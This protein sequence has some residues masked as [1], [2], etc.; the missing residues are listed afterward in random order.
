MTGAPH[1]VRRSVGR[2]F[3]ILFEANVTG[4]SSML[5]YAMLLT[6][7]PVALLGLFVAGQV[8]KSGSVEHSVLRDLSEI[9]PGATKSTLTTL[10]RQIRVSTTKTGVLALVASVW[11]GAS[12]WG[13][14][15]TAFARIYHVPARN[16]WAQKRF[17]LAMLLV[18]LVFMLSMVA[19]PTV[20][21][22]LQAGARSLPFDLAR[23]GGLVYRLSLGFAL[24]LLFASL[25]VIYRAVPNRQVPW[26]AVWPGAAAA[27]LLIA[28]LA[29][30]FPL[31]LTQIS[32]IAQFGTTIVF[33]LIVLAWFYVLAIIILAGGVVNSM[34]LS[35]LALPDASVAADCQPDELD[36]STT[37]KT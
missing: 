22:L 37:V 33:V 4:L 8:L 10:L 28:V 25:C 16:W 21:S 14:L 13:A 26:R 31:Y 5:A 36:A 24:V 11:F 2:F 15:D 32:T 1:R 19:A 7:I 20:I 12:F 34:R 23:I 6:V 9:F 29:L 30:V 27:T 3:K 18:L 35:G 17:G